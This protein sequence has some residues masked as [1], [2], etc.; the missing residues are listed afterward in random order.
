MT[1]CDFCDEDLD[2][3]QELHI[4]WL[5]E[6]EEELNSHQKDKAKKAKR[7]KK[8]A[9]EAKRRERKRKLGYGAATGIAAVFIGFI[10]MQLI[11]SS[12]GNT[13]EDID[14]SDQPVMGNESAEVTVVKFGDFA[15]PACSQFVSDT[16]PQLVENY[17]DTGQVKFVSMD[18]PLQG[19]EPQASAAAE[20]AEC[21]YSQDEEQYWNYY[22]A[23]YAN[24]NMI[25]YDT[26]GLMSLANQSTSGLNNPELRQCIENGETSQAVSSD[27]TFGLQNDVSVTPS[28]FVNGEYVRDWTFGNLQSEIEAELE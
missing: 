2:D 10:A 12:G 15:C 3:K 23:L 1:D 19:H 14:I 17:V 7:E 9:K 18:F 4:H 22:D 8:E 24:Q 21:V 13:I 11:Q 5:E 26:E 28:I 16:K 6:H 27:K 20:A 25:E